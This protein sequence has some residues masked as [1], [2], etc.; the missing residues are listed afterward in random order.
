MSRSGKP[1]RSFF[2]R[3]IDELRE[4]H[5]FTNA[6]IGQPR[7]S[8]HFTSGVIPGVYYDAFFAKDERVIAS[9]LIDV[10]DGEEN[11]R[12][13]DYLKQDR[14]KIEAEFGSRLEWSNTSGVRACSIR[15]GRP[16]SIEADARTLQDIHAW[17]IENLLK[18]KKVFGK[19]LRDYSEMAKD[20]SQGKLAALA[21]EALDEFRRGETKPLDE[22]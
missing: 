9:V 16:G 4:K 20:P 10:K 11:R 2:Q 21:D 22:L 15:A 3:L 19:R 12:I 18:L 13:F 14:A 1:Y 8:H 6:Q 5:G 7:N 17:L